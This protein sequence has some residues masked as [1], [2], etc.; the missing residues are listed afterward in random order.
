VPAARCL[1]VEDS[2]SGVAAARTAGC[3]VVGFPGLVEGRALL[4][5]GAGRLV[6]SL[7]EVDL[8][9]G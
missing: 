9:D 5:A 7:D 6:A 8:D 4:A 2:A 1:A 3:R